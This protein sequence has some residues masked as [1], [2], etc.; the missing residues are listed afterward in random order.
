MPEFEG[1]KYTEYI[2]TPEETAEAAQAV[3][4]QLAAMLP[5]EPK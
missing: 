2:M 3:F 1:E 4:G 5:E